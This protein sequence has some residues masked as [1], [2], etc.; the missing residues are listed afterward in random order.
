MQ[1][2]ARSESPAAA[3]HAEPVARAG[4]HRGPA[5]RLRVVL[6]LGFGTVGFLATL[7]LSALVSHEASRPLEAEV[8]GQLAEIAGQMA[9][10]LD[11]G[12]FE[13]WRDIQIASASD[14]LR[15][16]GA[17]AAAKRAVMA[18]L[19]TTYPAYSLI[20]LIDADGRVAVTSTG[21]LEGA[22]VSD[23]DYFRAGR[24]RAFVG[25]VHPARLL[26][27]PPGTAAAREP[28]RLLDLA[29]PVRATDGRVLGVLAAHLDWA[30]ARDMAR[31][32]EG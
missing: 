19:Q 18:R 31:L 13:R 12:M 32:L 11:L 30:W 27:A 2:V 9:R 5:P 14:S 8:G 22:D 24:E 20:G 16:P 17:G 7:P 6:A 10:G 25:D 4:L 3:A 29:A 15:D 26:Q 28:P 1:A 23:R 21:A